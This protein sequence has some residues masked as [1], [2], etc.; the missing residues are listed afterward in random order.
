MPVISGT[1]HYW[2][3]HFG[4]GI[5]GKL[6]WETAIV[7]TH[8]WEAG[9]VEIEFAWTARN[10]ETQTK[11]GPAQVSLSPGQRSRR[12]DANLEQR[13][14]T[15]G[16]W[17]LLTFRDSSIKV[18]AEAREMA[19]YYLE[20]VPLFRI[21]GRNRW[22]RPDKREESVDPALMSGPSFEGCCRDYYVVPLP[23]LALRP[24]L[25]P[26]FPWLHLSYTR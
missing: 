15:L 1:P 6:G 17:A 26:Q 19:L 10:R 2:S 11:G 7:T 13:A 23:I 4:E 16:L 21:S 12:T 25:P 22:I 18:C 24:T 3:P 20:Y 5:P 14:G 9:I 8:C